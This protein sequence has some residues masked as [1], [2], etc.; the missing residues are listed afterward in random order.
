MSEVTSYISNN[1]REYKFK[2][3][4]A[5]NRPSDNKEI[6]RI[7]CKLAGSYLLTRARNL[8]LSSAQESSWRPPVLFL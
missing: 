7:L 5:A 1:C 6:P 4:W 2:Y 8:S 3:S